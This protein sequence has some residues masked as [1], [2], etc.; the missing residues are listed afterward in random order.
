MFA[1]IQEYSGKVFSR[2]WC[3]DL[4][5][6]HSRQSPP[7]EPQASTQTGQYIGK[8]KD[9]EET[10]KKRIKSYQE[11]IDN[12]IINRNTL[13]NEVNKLEMKIKSQK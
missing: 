3:I 4:F 9:L 5:M 12:L 6:S 13:L 10:M 11:E 2:Y 8:Q 7:T 1:R